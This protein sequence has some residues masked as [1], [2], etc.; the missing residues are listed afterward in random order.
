M[1]SKGSKIIGPAATV[2]LV[3]FFLP[4][5]LVSCGGQPV[6]SFSGWQLAAGGNVQTGFGAQ[7]VEGSPELF[8]IL[9]AALG[10]LALVYFVYQRQIA[11]RTVAYTAIGSAGLSL[12]ILLAKFSGAQSRA[13]EVGITAQLQYGFWGTVLGNVAV[14]IGAVLDLMEGGSQVGPTQEPST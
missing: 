9:L 3:C 2:A 8:L 13:A 12:L 1:L 7:P 5:I 4:W 10:C 14:I 6:A 11:I